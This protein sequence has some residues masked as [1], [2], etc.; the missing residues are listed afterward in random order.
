MPNEPLQ[1]YQTGDDIV[2]SVCRRLYLATVSRGGGVDMQKPSN[3]TFPVVTHN[4]LN[5]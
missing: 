2:D 3:C 1:I 4:P 5:H